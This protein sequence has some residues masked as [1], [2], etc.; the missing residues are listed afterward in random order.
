MLFEIALPGSLFGLL[1]REKVL[2][3]FFFFPVIRLLPEH[4]VAEMRHIFAIRDSLL[5]E[6]S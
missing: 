5:A 4:S 3:H 1:V 2:A 6:K